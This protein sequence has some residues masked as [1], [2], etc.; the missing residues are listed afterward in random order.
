MKSMAYQF[1]HDWFSHN[2]QNWRRW[3]AQFEGKPHVRALE[4]G[5]YEGRSTTWLLEH[6]LTHDTNSIECVDPF[7]QEYHG[8]FLANIAPWKQRVVLHRGLSADVLPA[9]GGEFDFV[10]VDGDHRP[11]AILSD[12][13]LSWPRL[14][15]GGLLIF[16]DYLFVPYEIDPELSVKWTQ[17]QA[18]AQITKHPALCP[19]TAIDGFLAALTGQYELVGQGYQL[20]IR[21]LADPGTALAS[22]T[23]TA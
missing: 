15:I 13:V 22:L 10:Y 12:A 21:K 4:I 1:T 8:R 18:L 23:S 2:I 14:K 17:E 11:F 20:V 6:V 7:R 5:S 16:D 3:L 19:K 9:I